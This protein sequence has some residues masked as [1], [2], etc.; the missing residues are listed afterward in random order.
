MS[1]LTAIYQL[2]KLEYAQS[3]HICWLEDG[4]LVN[5]VT[6]SL[7]LLVQ[8]ARGLR[9][10]DHA[11]WRVLVEYAVSRAMSASL[12]LAMDQY[13]RPCGDFPPLLPI[14]FIED[15]PRPNWRGGTVP[16]LDESDV[17]KVTGT[18]ERPEPERQLILK[19]EC[20]WSHSLPRLRDKNPHH[21]KKNQTKA[22]HWLLS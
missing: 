16:L 12:I 17:L 10:Q 8:A 22:T 20:Q 9:R 13:L 3:R 21:A 11:A 5:D 1:Q 4:Q 6:H 18:T 14:S 2:L 15:A 19:S 7:R